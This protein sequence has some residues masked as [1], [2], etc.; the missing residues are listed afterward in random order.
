MNSQSGFAHALLNPELPCPSGLKTCNGSDP[1]LRFALYR[2]NVMVSLI[3]ALADTYPVVQA[4]VGEAFFRAMAKVFVQANPPRSRVMAYY[5][6]DFA[7]FASAFAPAASVPYLADV[8]RLEM[9]RVLAYHAADAPPIDPAS[10]Q[11]ALADPQQLLSMRLVLHPSVH[12]MAS[13]YAVFSLWAAHQGTLCIS[14][15]D[16]D[17][18]EAVLVFRHGLEVDTLALAPGP[19]QFLIALK[20]G[21]ALAEAA[22]AAASLDREFDLTQTLALLLRWQLITHASTGDHP[23]EY[24]H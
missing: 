8:A 9:A 20:R 21:D 15:V 16:A 14:S 10:L 13:P 6:G 17:Q 22:H 24:P 2:N 4:L 18:P 5:G 19:A 7:A 3:D 11:G 12:V 1:E 23:H